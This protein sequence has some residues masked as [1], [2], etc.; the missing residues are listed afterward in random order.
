MSPEQAR[1]AAA[2][3]RAD[4]YAVGVMLYEM[5]AGR[6]PFVA[7]S[8]M[9]VL[10]MH[11]EEP[12]PPLAQVSA[13][14]AKVSPTLAAVVLRALAKDPARRWRSADAFARALEA[15]P[16][17]GG[18]EAQARALLD[19]GGVGMAATVPGHLPTAKDAGSPSGPRRRRAGAGGLGALLVVALLVGGGAFA[20]S[21]LGPRDRQR[22]RAT[23]ADAWKRAR[24]KL[25]SARPTE[26]RPRPTANTATAKA[27]TPTT[28]APTTPAPTTPAP[29]TPAPTTTP[30]PAT[31]APTTPAPTT[32]PAPEPPTVAQPV[33]PPPT[34]AP[35][36][37]DDDDEP[38]PDPADTPGTRLEAE[39]VRATPPAPASAGPPKLADAAKLL[40]A[41]RTD[42]AIQLLYRLRR[43]TPKSPDVALLLGHAYFKKLWRS[44][45]LR[46]YTTAL[47]LR[48]SLRKDAR[49]RK[50]VVTALENPTSRRASALIRA[51]L[52]AAA[53]PELRA[54]ARTSPSP[55]A[56]R[57]AAS[58]AA[59]LTRRSAR[60][61]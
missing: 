6:R 30:A 46:E 8:A 50:N 42:E 38:T 1:G 7:D 45:G 35:D 49:L 18:S 22:V 33:P 2:D 23:L 36:D 29:T 19:E 52:G 32:T 21:R 3:E 61:R 48:P 27:A 39:A 4:L 51:H 25:S 16:E 56:K 59:E 37:D 43:A 26:T 12:P 57:R 14:G 24:G 40:A 9:G 17:G 47:Q 58:L 10:R 53:L 13:A 54:A 44:D 55:K 20:W 34:V 41:N 15:T 60:R 11:M 5:L 31:P 28:P